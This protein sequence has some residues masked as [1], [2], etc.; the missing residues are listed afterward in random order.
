MPST[1]PNPIRQLGYHTLLISLSVAAIVILIVD[2][3][4]PRVSCL[5]HYS[6]YTQPLYDSY[7]HTSRYVAVRDGTR[8]AMDIYRPAADGRAVTGRFPVLW[9]PERYHRTTYNDGRLTTPVERLARLRKFL[10]HG[11][12]LVIV[13]VRGSGASFGTRDGPFSPTEARDAYDITEWLASQPW[14]NGRIGMWGRSYG[15]IAQYFAAAEAPP[16][17]VTIFPEMALFDLYSFAYHGGIMRYDFGASWSQLVATLDRVKRAPAVDNDP[18]EQLLTAAMAEHQANVDVAEMFSQLPFRDSASPDTAERVYASRSPASY[19]PEINRSGVSIYQ[20]TGWFDVW[21]RDA[22]RWYAN[23]ERP[24]KI[25]IGPWS[26]LGAAD[27]SR[28]SE[29]LRWFD[30]WLKGIDNGVMTDPPI[31]YYTMGAPSRAGWYAAR[32]WPLP[33]QVATKFFFSHERSGSVNSSNDGSLTPTHPTRKHEHESLVDMSMT[34]GNATR[35]TAGYGGPFDYGNMTANDTKGLTFTTAP[36]PKALEV[37][38]HPIAHLTLHCSAADV[39][40]IVYLEDVDTAGISHYVTEGALRAS[41][42]KASS[43]P[44]KV[45]GV[46]FQSGRKRDQSPLPPKEV[47]IAIDLLP[48]SYAF[49]RGHRVRLTVAF[50][51]RDNLASTSTPGS[52]VAIRSGGAKASHLELPV[53]P[54]TRHDRAA[55]PSLLWPATRWSAIVLL[56]VTALACACRARRRRDL[57]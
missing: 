41:H 6:G 8:L 11:Y 9:S 29:Q 17:L 12:V 40:L 19:L 22:L 46:P 47:E 13:D 42:R 21:P 51:D 54:E 50:A 3:F 35:W 49:D 57:V 20:M 44:Y 7:E 33:E 18:D 30:H 53:I 28:S 1:R 31:H 37:T 24:Q 27:F 15:G 2:P 5:G 55:E 56:S 26:H 14:C 43:P 34:S 48:T 16:H 10:Y 25:V 38:G 39:D 45:N 23:I 52:T 32:E 4:S 36:L